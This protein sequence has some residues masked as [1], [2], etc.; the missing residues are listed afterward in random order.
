MPVSTCVCHLLN[1][2][3]ARRFGPSAVFY[4]GKK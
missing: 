1:V 3:A 4:L 2:I